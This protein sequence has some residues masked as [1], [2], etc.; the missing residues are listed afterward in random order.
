MKKAGSRV[1]FTDPKSR[2]TKA[3]V[4]N[5]E[6]EAR[7]GRRASGQDLADKYRS[8][9][10]ARAQLDAESGSESEHFEAQYNDFRA[11]RKDVQVRTTV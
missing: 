3:P 10:Q 8:R 5:A 7:A 11:R 4:G 2:S 1:M 6:D 9:P